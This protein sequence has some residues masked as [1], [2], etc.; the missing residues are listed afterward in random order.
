MGHFNPRNKR[1]METLKAET[2][3]GPNDDRN[4]TQNEHSEKPK[5]K[6]T[7]KDSA[8]AVNLVERIALNL[9]ELDLNDVRNH[10]SSFGTM[11]IF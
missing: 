1:F 5:R 11:E 7:K 10:S 9:D 3:E 2:E 4:G 6:N 8:C